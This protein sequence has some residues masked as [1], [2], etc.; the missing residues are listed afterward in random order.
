LSFRIEPYP[1]HSESTILS[2]FRIA[3]HLCH[4]ESRHTFVIPNRAAKRNP[5][6]LQRH[7][8]TQTSPRPASTLPPNPPKR[9]NPKPRK[10]H[11]EENCN[12]HPTE[13]GMP[14]LIF[15]ILPDR[16][17]P[18][19]QG[20]HQENKPRNL[21]PQLMQ[22]PSAGT[23]RRRHGTAG[24]PYHPAALDLLRCD[25]RHH[26]DLLCCGNLI[27]GLDFNSL[28]RYNVASPRPRLKPF[29]GRRHPSACGN[30]LSQDG[31]RGTR[32]TSNSNS[33]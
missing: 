13:P 9:T 14:S 8:T 20:H 15:P 28:W 16:G 19:T 12:R 24:C 32:W 5:L 1:C 6:S 10:H 18:K 3:P 11:C 17:A 7:R 30:V 31:D 2:S 33:S 25:P 27:H 22:H 4:S 23:R 29:N 26:P 21:Q